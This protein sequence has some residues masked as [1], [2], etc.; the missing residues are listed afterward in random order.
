MP[1]NIHLAPSFAPGFTLKTV[2]FCL[3]A[4]H[5]KST[6][7]ADQVH[8]KSTSNPRYVHVIFEYHSITTRVRSVYYPGAVYMPPRCIP[9]KLQVYSRYSTG[10]SLM[11]PE[12]NPGPPLWHVAVAQVHFSSIPATLQTQPG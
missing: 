9:G 3:F 7:T 4:T 6:T 5:C 1:L 2:V 8:V 11:H 10:V 12:H